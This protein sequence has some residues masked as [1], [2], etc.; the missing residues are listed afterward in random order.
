MEK[1]VLT[2]R[3]KTLHEVEFFRKKIGSKK[4]HSSNLCQILPKVI[5]SDDDFCQKWTFHELMIENYHYKPIH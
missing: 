5:E 4:N 3:S 2:E 1:S